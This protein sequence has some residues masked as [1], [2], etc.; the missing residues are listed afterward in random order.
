MFMICVATNNRE[1]LESVERW[2]DEI[3]EIEQSIPIALILTKAD[4][5]GMMD[6]GV[7]V[8]MIKAKAKEMNLVMWAKTSSKAWEDFNV[9]KAFN[10]ALTAAYR[11]KYGDESDEDSDD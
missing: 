1:S 6:D 2:K 8:S 5:L 11:Y 3:Q 7:D 4:F 9:H 10:K